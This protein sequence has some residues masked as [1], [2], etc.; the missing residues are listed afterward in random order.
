MTVEPVSRIAANWWLFLVMGVVSTIAGVLAIVYPDI[1]LL[2]IGIFAGVSLLFIGALELVDAITGAPDSRALSAIVGV[3]AM[4]A[5]L[6]C[7]RRPGESLLA[8][9][10]VIGIYLVI[11]GLI[12]FIRAFAVLEDRALSLGLALLDIIL[13][14]VIL[15]LPELGLVTLAILFAISLIARG[16]FAIVAAFR[17]RSLGQRQEPGAPAPA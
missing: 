17:L 9:V 1:T 2:A 11:T 14:I 15:S 10:I 4:L 7:L 16:V 6:I 8:L 12:R 13:G 5:G 3:L